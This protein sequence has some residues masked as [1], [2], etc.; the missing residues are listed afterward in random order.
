MIW[1]TVAKYVIYE[2]ETPVVSYGLLEIKEYYGG[3]WRCF[4]S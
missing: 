4:D 2:F 3:R 1:F